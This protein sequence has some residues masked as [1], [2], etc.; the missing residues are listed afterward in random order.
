M[1]DRVC[2]EIARYLQE[3][4]MREF[5]DLREVRILCAAGEFFE[6]QKKLGATATNDI[7]PMLAADHTRTMPVLNKEIGKAR[8]R[9][10]PPHGAMILMPEQPWPIS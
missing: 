7:H 9:R 4:K 3:S 10:I 1:R 6:A 5:T 8:A 2:D